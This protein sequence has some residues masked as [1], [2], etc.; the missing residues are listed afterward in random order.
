M[1]ITLNPT[2]RIRKL[3]KG[4][5]TAA[6]W[7]A[8]AQDIAPAAAHIADMDRSVAGMGTASH[9]PDTAPVGA[10]AGNPD[11]R[12]GTAAVAPEAAGTAD[13]AAEAGNTVAAAE[14]AGSYL[15]SYLENQTLSPRSW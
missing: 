13:R 3:A 10:A 15:P 5:A 1:L 2:Q 12:T 6:A 8:S 9:L 7:A 4:Q 11:R 14:V